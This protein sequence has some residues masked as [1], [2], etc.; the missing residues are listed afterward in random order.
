M[1]ILPTPGDVREQ[2]TVT[3]AGDNSL[4][5]IVKLMEHDQSEPTPDDSTLH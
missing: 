1:S 3:H 5:T 2:V 4:R